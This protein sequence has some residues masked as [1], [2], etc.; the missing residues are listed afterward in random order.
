MQW[1][2][3]VTMSDSSGKAFPSSAIPTQLSLAAFDQASV[4][5]FFIERRVNPRFMNFSADIT[6]LERV[7]ADVPEPSSALLFAIAAG[8]LF[9]LRKRRRPSRS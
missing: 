8:G 3:F 2:S 4:S 1:N 9:G 6:S 7:D 5:G